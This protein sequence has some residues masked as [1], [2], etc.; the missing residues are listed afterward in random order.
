MELLSGQPVWSQRTALMPG[1]GNGSSGTSRYTDGTLY[2]AV[3]A[4]DGGCRDTGLLLALVPHGV[5]VGVQPQSEGLV[6]QGPAFRA[7][8]MLGSP[9]ASLFASPAPGLWAV[10]PCRA[11][12]KGEC[13][14]HFSCPRWA[15]RGS[16]KPLELDRDPSLSVSSSACG[17]PC[18]GRGERGEPSPG[19]HP[20]SMG[21]AAGQSPAQPH[22]RC[23]ANRGAWPW[24]G[25]GWRHRQPC[26]EILLSTSLASDG[27]FLGSGWDLGAQQP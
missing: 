21:A 27:L 9:P 23:P 20:V 8:W 26:G 19:E 24:G 16:E 13:L 18:F 6:R 2:P 15:T 11:W 3:P 14:L 4:P 22:W 17:D 1:V 10:P 7:A 12:G 5:P 25:R